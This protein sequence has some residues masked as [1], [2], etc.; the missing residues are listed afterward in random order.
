MRA[1]GGGGG[2]GALVDHFNSY[3]NTF[4]NIRKSETW[5]FLSCPAGSCDTHVCHFPHISTAP[6]Y[7]RVKQRIGVPDYLSLIKPLVLTA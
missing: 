6:V 3:N 1:E 5:I 4:K 2:V 7:T